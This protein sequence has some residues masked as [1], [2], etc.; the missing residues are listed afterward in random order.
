MKHIHLD[1]VGGIAGDMFCAAV[2]DAFPVYRPEL[3]IRLNELNISPSPSI[4]VDAYNDGIIQGLQFNVTLQ[5]STEQRGHVHRHWQDIKHFIEEAPL[6]KEVRSHALGIF[7]LLAEAEAKV[8][9][10]SVDSV[11]FHEVGNWDSIVDIVAAALLIHWL[12][13]SSWSVSKLPLG[14]GQVNTAHGRLPIPAPATRELLKGFKVFSDGLSGERITPTGAAILKYLKPSDTPPDGILDQSGYGHGQKKFPGISNILCVQVISLT[15][16]TTI[17]ESLCIVQC[18]IDDQTPEDLSTAL[19]MLRSHEGVKDVQ[20]FT[21][22]GKKGRITFSLQ[23]LVTPSR[24]E[25]VFQ[26][27]FQQTSTIGIRWFKAQRRVLKR[28]E[29]TIDNNRVKYANR[30]GMITVKAEMDDIGQHQRSRQKREAIRR[31]VEAKALERI[32]EH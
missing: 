26:A 13:A 18:E 28:F 10:V 22:Y 17:D 6:E 30:D 12:N 21:S 5:S 2:L 24:Q 1:V 11:S 29:D 20:Q 27:I 32:R 16:D 7:V 3:L 15:P 4:D 19:D 14:S 31:E 9:G 25:S 23:L 8:H